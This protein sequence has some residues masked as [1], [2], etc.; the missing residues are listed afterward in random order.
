MKKPALGG[1]QHCNCFNLQW[2]VLSA[3]GVPVNDLAENVWAVA[4]NDPGLLGLI[5][6]FVWP[7]AYRQASHRN[8]GQACH[9]DCIDRALLFFLVA[10]C[11]GGYPSLLQASCLDRLNLGAAVLAFDSRTFDRLGTVRAGAITGYDKAL[12]IFFC[13]FFCVC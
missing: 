1:L 12:H 4:Q 7:S 8:D 13:W 6:C 10:A 11:G 3:H 2:G 9:L 5:L